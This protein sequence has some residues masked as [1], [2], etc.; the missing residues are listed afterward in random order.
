MAL[1]GPCTCA[2]CTHMRTKCAKLVPGQ[3]SVYFGKSEYLFFLSP[4]LSTLNKH[5]FY[6]KAYKESNSHS[7]GMLK[8]PI[9]AQK[10]LVQVIYI[11]L[12][13]HQ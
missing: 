2:Y 8:G 7:L 11:T 5:S 6:V 9:N 1:N 4:N 10:G 3:E 13:G 12:G